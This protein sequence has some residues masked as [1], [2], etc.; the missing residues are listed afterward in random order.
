MYREVEHLPRKTKP[1]SSNPCTAESEKKEK[2]K[3]LNSYS[4]FFNTKMV[5]S[6]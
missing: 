2:K 1:L 5:V 6:P 4:F 3:E